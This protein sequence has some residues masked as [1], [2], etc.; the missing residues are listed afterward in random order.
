M[1]E[2]I[3]SHFKKKKKKRGGE[4]NDIIATMSAIKT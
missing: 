1:D 3:W 4:D 2:I